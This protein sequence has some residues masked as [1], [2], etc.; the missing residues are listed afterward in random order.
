MKKYF[1]GNISKQLGDATESRQGFGV[2]SIFRTG[3]GTEWP[4]ILVA[5]VGTKILE[6]AGQNLWWDFGFHG[7]GGLATACYDHFGGDE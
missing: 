1:L 3:R 5:A 2:V 7:S 4:L 6:D